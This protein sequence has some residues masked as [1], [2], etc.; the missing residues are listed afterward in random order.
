MTDLT[1]PSVTILLVIVLS[2]LG[3]ILSE[4]LKVSYPTILIALGLCL[5]FLK[6]ASGL[7]T[8][9]IGSDIILGFVVPPLIFE[10]AMRTRYEVLKKVHKTVILLAIIGVVI[11]TLISGFVLNVAAGLPLAV[12]LTFGVIVSP[13]D[14][15]SIVNVLNSIRA[16]EALTTTLEA[17]AYFNDATAV[18]LYPIALSLSFNP[19]QT[20]THLSYTL[21]GG[22]LA[23]IT[24]S[25]I[26]EALHRLINE[27]LAETYFTIAVMFGSYLL[28]DSFGFSGL[29]AVAIAGLYMG[30]RT[31]QVAMSKKT[32]TTVTT[33]WDVLAF[34]ATSFA[35][36]L[37]GLKV[38]VGLLITYTPLIIAAF[39]AVS[40]AR[41]LSVYPIVSLTRALREKIPPSWTKVLGIAGLRGEV[42]VALA[43]SLPDSFPQRE[44][45]IAMTFGVALLSLIIQGEILQAYMKHLKL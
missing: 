4:K 36:L 32:R 25:L 7:S 43:L 1:Q 13:T 34:I 39:L 18:V 9:P 15:I 23:G 28:A 6:T 17:E 26:A 12:A 38:N 33:F 20:T 22:V 40:L 37:L 27:P 30:N 42:S 41:I 44:T 21:A 3:A 16:P 45:I 19:L 31:M 8:L 11:S 10:A 29:V 5:S 35:F 14:P 24:V 2:F